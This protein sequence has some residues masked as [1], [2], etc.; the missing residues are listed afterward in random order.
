VAQGQ[1]DQL[2]VSSS[3]TSFSMARLRSTKSDRPSTLSD[4]SLI[5]TTIIGMSGSRL[6]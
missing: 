5:A 4:A 3:L 6:D 2:P 1:F